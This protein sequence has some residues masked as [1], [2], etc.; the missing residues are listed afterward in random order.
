[1]F[2]FQRQL[3]PVAAALGLLLLLTC[4]SIMFGG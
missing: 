3:Y 4:L 1:M 2:I